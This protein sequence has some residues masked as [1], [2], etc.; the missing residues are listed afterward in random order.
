MDK[1]IHITMLAQEA[2]GAKLALKWLESPQPEIDGKRPFD[3]WEEPEAF[4]ILERT[5]L[6][7]KGLP[8][9]RP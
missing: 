1:K 5:L 8:K 4:V 3:V 6:R 2:M 7:M 9:I